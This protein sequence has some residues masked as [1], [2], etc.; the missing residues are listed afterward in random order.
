[1]DIKNQYKNYCK[2]KLAELLAVLKLDTHVVSASGNYLKSHDGKNILDMVSGFG[3][4]VLGHNHP[5]IVE[6][7]I[8]ALQNNLPVSVQG[9]VRG[10]SARLA[11]RL[12]DLLPPGSANYYV[13]FANSGTE[14]VE[15][16]IKHA[17]KVRF[18]QVLREYERLSR[19]LN[20]F[21]YRVE[22]MPSCPELPGK[23]KDL[24]D[25]RDDLD[26]YNLAQFESFQN[27][28]VMLSFKGGYHGKTISSLKVTF[29]KSF[30]ESFEGLSAIQPVFIDPETPERITEI[31][32][33]NVCTFYYP[34]IDNGKVELR[35]LR[36]TKV[37]GLIFE[38]VMG[39][40]GIK[41]LSDNT[42]EYLAAHHQTNDLP[43]IIDEI[44]TG[45]G[46]SGHIYGYA[47]TAL[48]RISPEY[49]TLSKALGGAIAKIGATLIRKDCYEPDFGILHTSTFG[50]DD[51]SSEV[52]LSTLN[53]L[54]RNS[55]D[56]L[57]KIR[58]TGKQ[59]IDQLDGLRT[60]FPEIIK[61]I[62]GK[63]LMLGI[64]F[65][66]L[67]ERSPFFRAAG[68]Q[69]VLSLLIASYLLEYY[70][71]RVLAPLTTMLKGNPGKNR[72]SVIRIQPPATVTEWE[73]Q[74]LIAGLREVCGVIRN[75]NEFCLIGHLVG[76]PVPSDQ[77][78]ACRH[79]ET[80][81]PVV[82]DSQTID[83]RAGFIVHPVNLETLVEYYFPSFEAYSWNAK[84]VL[85]WWD[86][87][88]RF[89]EPVHV[90]NEYVTSNEFTIEVNLV[91]VPY[92]PRYINTHKGSSMLAREMRDKVQ[93][94][95]TVARELGDDNIPVSI[96][97]LG[98]Y[99]S[100]I[101]Q[102]AQT[103]NDYEVPVTTGNAYT[104]GLTVQ[105]I[106]NAAERQ[107]LDISQAKVAVVGAAGN[108]GLVTA[109]IL[110]PRVK[111]LILLGSQNPGSEYRLH[112]ARQQCLHE[113]LKIVQDEQRRSVDIRETSI[114]GQ[115]Y[116]I[117]Q[118]LMADESDFMADLKME[119]AASEIT[120]EHG[121]ALEHLLSGKPEL[122]I[123]VTTSD[124]RLEDC[125]IVVVATNTE[126]IDLIRPDQLKPG[127]IVCCTSVPS[128]LSR[129]FDK[130]D[131]KL[132]FDG[133]LA[134]L[135]E[136][137]EINFVGMPR[138]GMSY[139][140]LAET[141]VLAFD[142]QNHSYSKGM[143]EP[144]QV[145]HIIEKAALHGFDLGGLKFA[146]QALSF[147]A[148]P[149]TGQINIPQGDMNV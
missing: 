57:S 19:L 133:G 88:S 38:I 66:A 116:Q 71:I 63:G 60:E 52:A 142:G 120:V 65:T 2:P 149:E 69:G 43:Y 64:E 118:Y 104:V 91:F 94:A 117:Y 125:D 45:C 124:S 144:S 112:Y 93:D 26:E 12:N 97:G 23:N 73:I 67:E 37:I 139:G 143:L 75:N 100:I 33:Q 103:I 42:L 99:T 6:T 56:F 47:D 4:A 61:E 123:E 130:E 16:S 146:D 10:A 29:N 1:M 113:L 49:I 86:G 70:H 72:L 5:E 53:V 81:W 76:E 62:R 134:K 22:R 17:Y 105:G 27:H 126:N 109:Q 138:H 101:T 55:N 39:E 96:V 107:G 119:M 89:L 114:R 74:R 54:T 111:Q 77:R 3:A 30:R 21:Y 44:Q 46:R 137:S 136:A 36:L 41:P 18:E 141:L 127:A 121:K 102:N 83:A 25:F 31:I 110:F 82:E 11:K 92:L 148:D 98:A 14:S 24:I 68:K 84:L 132:A 106:L 40:G 90:K 80:R 95:V 35:P 9:T 128:N 7:A 131:N 50:E 15:A 48:S 115:G 28:P 129:L 85:N 51:F 87:I 34:V 58:N 78:K 13:N 135:P 79:F 8:H 108:I 32:Q 147:N 20:N 59:L 140:C 145:Y 122:N